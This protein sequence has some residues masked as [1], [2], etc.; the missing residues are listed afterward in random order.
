MPG[1]DRRSPIPDPTADRRPPTADRRPPTAD[2]STIPHALDAPPESLGSPHRPQ[3]AQRADAAVHRPAPDPR[4]HYPAGVRHAARA[5]VEGPVSGAH[6][7]DGRSHRSHARSAAA[8]RGR[9][10]R[11]HAVG[12]RA[13]R[14]RVGHP[15]FRPRQ[16]RPGHR[17]CDRARARSD[18]AGHDDRLRR[19]SHLDA[20]RVRRPRVRD[21]YVAGARR[22]GVAVPGDGAAEGPPHRGQ[23]APRPGCLCEGRHP[24]NHPS[25]RCPGW[26]RLRLRVRRRHDRAHDDGRADDD[27]QHV[28][29]GGRTCGVRES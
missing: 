11:R 3:T 5:R 14:A 2:R 29:R 27:L 9:D 12:S 25:A 24:A 15:L 20:R 17:P 22:S 6:D 8:V 26:R 7:R 1:S 19:Q 13:Q 21:R 28:H 16:W 23:G 18:A 10:G 4:G